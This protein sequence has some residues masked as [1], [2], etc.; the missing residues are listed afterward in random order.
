[1]GK[2]R[3][4]LKTS[5]HLCSAVRVETRPSS[6]ERDVVNEGPVR[7]ILCSMVVSLAPSDI[8]QEILPE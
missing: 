7:R 5:T 3:S 4:K 1:M 8:Q 6:P 2:F